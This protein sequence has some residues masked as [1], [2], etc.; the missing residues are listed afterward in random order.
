MAGRPGV[1]V[2]RWEANLRDLGDHHQGKAV[3]SIA[4]NAEQQLVAELG[5]RVWEVLPRLVHVAEEGPFGLGDAKAEVLRLLSANGGCGSVLVAGP[6]KGEGCSLI[7]LMNALL[8]TKSFQ[9]L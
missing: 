9:A 4:K 2:A 3:T 7:V 1:D 6:G 8:G 5:A